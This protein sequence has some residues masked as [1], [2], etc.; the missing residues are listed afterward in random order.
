MRLF[1]FL[2]IAATGFAQESIDFQLRFSS[3]SLEAGG[4]CGGV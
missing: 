4:R 1:L 3:F 2:A